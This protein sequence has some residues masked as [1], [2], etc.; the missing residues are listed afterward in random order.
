VLAAF[1][2]G[3]LLFAIAGWI[4]VE[5]WHRLSTPSPVLGG[6]MLWVA[7]AGLGVNLAAFRLLQS[8]D[9]DNLNVRAALLHVAGDLLGSVAA[10]A[11]ALVIIMTG[12]TPIDPILSVLVSLLIL[13][14]AARIVRDS[15]HILLEGTPS[16]VDP[17]QIGDSLKEAI[18]SVLDVHHVHAWS[19]SQ[20]RRLVTLHARIADT[21]AP[22]RVV[23][24]IK[25]HLHERHGIEHATV[26]I[27]FA[28]C[29]DRGAASPH[30]A[31]H[32]D[33]G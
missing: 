29:S 19:L 7:L 20:D 15:G 14:S 25:H 27:E 32:S 2:N 8:G 4:V 23:A 5:A 26:E 16:E 12:W 31:G 3:L 18:P 13:G 6:V 11:A 21:E 30:A 22:D 24:A 10:I 33:A 28:H 1:T 9:S 17:R